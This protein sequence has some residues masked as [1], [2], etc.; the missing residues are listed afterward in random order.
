MGGRYRK[1][2]CS[3]VKPDGSRCK[4]WAMRDSEPPVC[5]PHGGRGIGAPRGN[6]NRRTHG[7]YRQRRELNDEDLSDPEMRMFSLWPEI[8]LVKVINGRLMGQDG[9]ALPATVKGDLYSC[10]I[11]GSGIVRRLLLTERKIERRGLAGDQSWEHYSQLLLEQQIELKPGLYSRYYTPEAVAAASKAFS[12]I[13]E[14]AR[15]RKYVDD[16]LDYW[17]QRNP[18]VKEMVTMARMIFSYVNQIR[19]LAEIQLDMVDE[20]AEAMPEFIRRALDFAREEGI[21]VELGEN[22]KQILR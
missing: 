11:S 4:A 13:D 5:G 2:R 21:E 15:R 6:Q 12:L 17:Q 9:E 7:L 19:G 8:V 18:E 16:A 14:I 20:T 1:E 22:S 10:V 3:H